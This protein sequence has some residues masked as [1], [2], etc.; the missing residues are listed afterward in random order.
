MAGSSTIKDVGLKRHLNS[1]KDEHNGLGYEDFLQLVDVAKHPSG[2]VNNNA[3]ARAFGVDKRTV[4]NWL[5]VHE[6]EKRNG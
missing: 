1:T 2:K 3:I 5:D 4:R 6:K